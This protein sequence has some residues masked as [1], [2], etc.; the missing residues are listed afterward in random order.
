MV[1]FITSCTQLSSEYKRTKEE[2]DSLKLHILKNEAEMN[3]LLSILTAVEEDIQAIRLTEDILMLQKDSELSDS[4]RAKLKK[5]INLINESL[6]RNKQILADL[7]E[8]LNTS[9]INFSALQRSI[10]RLSK[11][12]T[13]KTNMV[14]M[15]QGELNKKDVRIGE[16]S[17]KIEELNT[18]VKALEEINQT[19]AEQINEQDIMLN[20]V[21]YCFGTKKE[22]KEQNILTGGGLFSKAKAMQG[23][24]N[25]DYFLKVDKRT[26]NSIHLYTSKATMI[27]NH[28]KGSYSFVKEPDGKLTLVIIHPSVF[29]SL[30]SF[31]VIE[32]K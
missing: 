9:A 7:Q 3:E 20:V 27:T 23:E 14:A 2:N 18:D 11:D 22:L 15:L 30:S 31:L 16:L 19:Q 8:K 13:E 28:P 26:V 32:V 17:T 5:D 29:W 25:L 12:M 21:Y 10:D 1:C 24:F 6:Q 4:R